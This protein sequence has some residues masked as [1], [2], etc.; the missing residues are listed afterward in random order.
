MDV[1]V[2]EDLGGG[3]YSGRGPHQAPEVDGT[4]E[5]TAA[6]AA[7]G[8]LLRVRVTG[9]DGVDL[10]AVPAAAGAATASAPGDGAPAAGALAAGPH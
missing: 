2:D 10:T 8:D 5:V 3:R 4:V 1:L 9:S 7:P 6:G